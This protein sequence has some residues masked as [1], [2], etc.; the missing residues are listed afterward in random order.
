MIK[1]EKIEKKGKNAFDFKNLHIEVGILKEKH[2]FKPKYNQFKSL[3]GVKA[4]KVD[5]SKRS[6]LSNAEILEKLQKRYQLMTKPKNNRIPQLEDQ[7]AKGLADFL[8]TGKGLNGVLNASRAIVRQPIIDGRYK[9][10]PSTVKQKGFNRGGIDTG[11]TFKDIE[12]VL[13]KDNKIYELK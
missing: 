1:I 13:V 12:A 4:R 2:N 9:N 8:V 7:I 11:D 6:I 3:G 10:K 5:K